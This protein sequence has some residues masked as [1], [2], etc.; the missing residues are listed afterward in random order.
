MTV[1]ECIIKELSQLKDEAYNEGH[2]VSGK[3][4][5]EAINVV[6]KYKRIVERKHH[7]KEKASEN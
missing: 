2:H 3:T 6:R 5:K 7:E 4:Y 1:F